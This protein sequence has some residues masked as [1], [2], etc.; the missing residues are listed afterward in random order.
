MELST[1]VHALFANSKKIN[2]SEVREADGYFYHNDE[3]LFSVHDECGEVES[4]ILDYYSEDM[5]Q[6]GTVYFAKYCFYFLTKDSLYITGSIVNMD[7]Y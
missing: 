7:R 6:S 3:Y 2:R 5:Y 1:T 4:E